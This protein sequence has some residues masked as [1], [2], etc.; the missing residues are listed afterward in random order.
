MNITQIRNA[1][2]LIEYAGMRFLIDPMLAD[3]GAYPGFPGSA[4]S[5]LRNP[6]VVLPYDVQQLLNVDAVIVTHT[7]LDHWDDAAIALIPKRMPIFVQ[8]ECDRSLLYQQ[9][10][11]HLTVIG[12]ATYIG[13]IQLTRTE[14]QHGSD[15]AYTDPEMAARMG[16]ACG[17][18]F[19]HE[20]EKTLYLIGDSV[21]MPAVE[22]TLKTIEPDVV[23]ANMGWAHTLLFGAIIMGAEDAIRIHQA[24]P[25]AQIV[26]T[27]MEAIN[28][29]LLT[30]S[31][32]QAF[33]HDN[34][35]AA[36]V[37]VPADGE[38]ITF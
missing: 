13:D 26:A 30:R 5:H 19:R 4:R 1:T 33:V 6:L 8:N 10:F 27:H 37:S 18:I 3:K 14:G 20:G 15:A 9:G 31:A 35:M 2:Q 34:G 38:M 17:V 32:L 23:V 25:R 29:C 36:F 12:E 16:A 28:H 11:T 24:V 7:H 22:R 21:W